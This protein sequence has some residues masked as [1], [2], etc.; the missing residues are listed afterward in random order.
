MGLQPIFS[1]R[2]C[3]QTNS[4]KF[5]GAKPGAAKHVPEY[6]TARVPPGKKGRCWRR[7]WCSLLQDTGLNGLSRGTRKDPPK[8]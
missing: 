3:A 1:L 6:L 2:I 7:T 8:V 5:T 4:F